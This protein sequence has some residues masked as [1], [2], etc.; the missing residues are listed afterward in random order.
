[1][2]YSPPGVMKMREVGSK[3]DQHLGITRRDREA[4][5]KP[6]PHPAQRLFDLTA[7]RG[8]LPSGSPRLDADVQEV[9][10]AREFEGSEGTRRRGE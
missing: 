2:R 4:G 8:F 7:H 9:Q 1:M 5:P 10:S 6:V 3:K